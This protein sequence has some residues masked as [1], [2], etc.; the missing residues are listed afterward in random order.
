MLVLVLRLDVQLYRCLVL[1]SLSDLRHF[2]DKEV[3][4]H[5]FLGVLI[6]QVDVFATDLR[7]CYLLHVVES[8][9]YLGYFF[10]ALNDD[11]RPFVADCWHEG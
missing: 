5:V 7:D 6:V 1:S 2:F 10:R 4:V 3:Q 9:D 8:F 11:N